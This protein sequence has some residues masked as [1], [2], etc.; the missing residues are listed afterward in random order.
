MKVSIDLLTREVALRLGEGP[1][2]P[3]QCGPASTLRDSVEALAP[4]AAAEVVGAMP[5]E[6]LDTAIP[7]PLSHTSG[8]DGS[9]R[10]LLPDD[11]MRLVAFR[12]EGWRRSVTETISPDSPTYRLQR[13]PVEAL[14]GSDSRPVCA[15]V[16]EEG[17]LWLEYYASRHKTPRRVE[18]ALYQPLPAIDPFGA[19]NLPTRAFSLV[20]EKIAAKLNPKQPS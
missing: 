4:D 2:D 14:R 9:G 10:L 18:V 5:A 16:R 13:Q 1:P 12:M 20:V 8:H 17:G 19:I 7:L 15:L 3:R 11:F 6:W